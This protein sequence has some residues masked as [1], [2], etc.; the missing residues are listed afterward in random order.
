[1]CY[2]LTAYLTELASFYFHFFADVD[3]DFLA[4]V[5]W[6]TGVGELFHSVPILSPLDYKTGQLVSIA[7]YAG[8]SIVV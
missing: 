1:M 6:G 4:Y 7:D 5:G 8:S 3:V 2:V